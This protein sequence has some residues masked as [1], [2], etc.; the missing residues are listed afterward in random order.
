M[1]YQR[2]E[3][4]QT[5]ATAGGFLAANTAPPLAAA[6][7][8]VAGHKTDWL[9]ETRWGVMYHYVSAFHGVINEEDEWQQ[10]VKSFD[11]PGLADEL[12]S[13]GAGYF[14]ITAR[15]V[16]LPLAPHRGYREGKFPGR[17]AHYPERHIIPWQGRHLGHALCADDRPDP[18]AGLS[19]ASGNWQGGRDDEL[20]GRPWQ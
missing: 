15:H 9:H 10:A 7:E 5:A 14:S 20:G 2:R 1:R 18:A 4:L 13:A 17:G 19:A 3:F 11:V 12:Q 16:G 8:Q 6:A